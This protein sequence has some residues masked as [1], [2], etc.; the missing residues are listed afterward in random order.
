M[1]LGDV[2]L[3]ARTGKPKKVWSNPR[4]RP[5]RVVQLAVAGVA[6]PAGLRPPS[7]CAARAAPVGI[8]S[9]HPLFTSLR[10]TAVFC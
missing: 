10:R 5:E 1:I 9:S 7:P 4:G 6:A 2:F 3:M 8:E